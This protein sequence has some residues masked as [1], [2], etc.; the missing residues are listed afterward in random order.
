[1]N[2]P[3]CGFE[4][5]QAGA[6]ECPRCGVVYAKWRPRAAGAPK[7]ESRMPPARKSR[8]AVAL[9]VV[10]VMGAL[11]LLV[12]FGLRHIP[13]PGRPET[14]DAQIQ[15]SVSGPFTF[16]PPARVEEQEPGSGSE[17]EAEPEAEPEPEPGPEQVSQ[18]RDI[19]R[20]CGEGVMDT[21]GVKSVRDGLDALRAGQLERGT[22]ELD[23]LRPRL[24]A[25]MLDQVDPLLASGHLALGRRAFDLEMWT[26]AA[27]RFA[28]AAG[29]AP[30]QAPPHYWLGR[31]AE[32][33]GDL[34]RA[35]AEY[36]EA[37]RLDADEQT[38][39]RLFT[40]AYKA[41][42]HDQA[43]GWVKKLVAVTRGAGKWN[44]WAAR[45]ARERPAESSMQNR[46]N[47]RFIIKYD[48]RENSDAAFAVQEALRDGF[49]ALTREL[50]IVPAQPVTAILY[51][52][53]QF[54]DVTRAPKWSGGRFDG[55]IRIPVGGVSRSGG[56]L[57]RK[58]V[59]H[60][61]VH[62][63]V[64]ERT[65]DRCPAWFHE[66]LA[67][68]YEGLSSGAPDGGNPRWN[69]R[70][71]RALEGSFGRLPA[72]LVSTAYNV[73]REAVAYIV[74]A[75]G[76]NTIP[77]LLDSLAGGS[78]MEDALRGAGLSYDQNP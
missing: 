39:E 16:V 65:H 5:E 44:A 27:S 54:H 51:T 2:C 17:P 56:P 18:G 62:A 59:F 35:G 52:G 46:V 73:S 31:L 61:L 22:G 20:P 8:L 40:L 24:H 30:K 48:G 66:G 33:Q 9:P 34:K 47:E 67:E 74:S 63:L 21:A 57:L 3:N 58:V 68:Y 4:A 71:L 43:A 26:E 49:L 6:A 14:S 13:V 64:A 41:N 10:A 76:E 32:K 15:T 19:K 72:R 36:E 37:A 77:R 78:S 25:C 70:V 75:K 11:A 55:K 45:L 53:Q 1:M 50:R 60:E 23:A 7:D 38:L 12:F 29:I 42:E 28:R 69:G